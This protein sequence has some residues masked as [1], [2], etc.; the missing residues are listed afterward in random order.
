MV[1][2]CLKKRC[3][4][5]LRIKHSD[6]TKLEMCNQCGELFQLSDTSKI[7]RLRFIGAT[8]LSLITIGL[9]LSIS[10]IFF[11]FSSSSISSMSLEGAYHAESTNISDCAKHTIKIYDSK[12]IPNNDTTFVKCDLK[13]LGEKGKGL[14]G[15]FFKTSENMFLSIDCQDVIFQLFDYKKDNGEQLLINKQIQK[16]TF[17]K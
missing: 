1:N 2:I 15:R 9:A 7:N 14:T 5:R 11:K 6:G 13:R 10:T 4:K 17:K 8:T 16:C 12:N 3:K